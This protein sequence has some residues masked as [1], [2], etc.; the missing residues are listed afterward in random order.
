MASAAQTCF[1]ITGFCGVGVPV[2]LRETHCRTAPPPTPLQS[3]EMPV[4]LQHAE[5]DPDAWYGDPADRGAFDVYAAPATQVLT[6][7]VL[8]SAVPV[9]LTT[10]SRS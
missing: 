8:A 5:L 4:G 10:V 6:A 7:T 9:Q 2:A 3:I 1:G